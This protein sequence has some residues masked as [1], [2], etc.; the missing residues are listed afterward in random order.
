VSD[1]ERARISR[2]AAAFDQLLRNLGTASNPFG[3]DPE[4]VKE[5]LAILSEPDPAPEPEQGTE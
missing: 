4:E 1:P 5:A 3:G 2:K